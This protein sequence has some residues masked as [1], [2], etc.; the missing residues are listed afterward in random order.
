MTTAPH[1]PGAAAAGPS[2]GLPVPTLP[3]RAGHLPMADIFDLYL[4]AY[5]GRDSTRSWRVE[6]WRSR[7]GWVLLQD[8]NDDHV[9]QHLEQ[10]AQQ[11]R[12]C[13]AGRDVEGRQ[14]FRARGGTLAPATLNR[15]AAALS[16][17]ATW[18][19]KKRIAPQGWLHP[20]RSIER[21][22]EN[23]EKTRFLDDAEC[24]RLL[25][26]CRASTWP[27]LRL[28]VLMA[29]TTGARRGELC[30]L[31]WK[32]IDLEGGTATLTRTKNGRA[33][34]LPLVPAVVEELHRFKAGG[35]TLVFRSPRAPDRVY[36][37]EGKFREALKAAG[38]RGVTFHTLRH[39]AASMLARNGATLVEIGQVL[40][41]CQLQT[42]LRYS[43][44]AVGHKAALVNRVLGG[45]R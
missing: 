35:P 10:L 36:H 7:I 21:R 39:S 45:L 30:G 5:D 40:G 19:I 38:I 24:R 32:D 28:L 29:L 34:V 23:N 18:C 26:A 9:H 2:A 6:W 27:R 4:Q 33:R 17:V 43:H 11:P 37:F 12:R 8:L 13:Y 1:T 25:D 15:Y 31:A 20:C 42:T 41:H 22:R 3:L 14:V 44:L 16:A